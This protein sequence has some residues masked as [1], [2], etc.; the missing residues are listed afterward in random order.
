M[1]ELTVSKYIDDYE[2]VWDHFV[3]EDSYKAGSIGQDPGLSDE[4]RIS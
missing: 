3:L 1:V 2:S 4:L